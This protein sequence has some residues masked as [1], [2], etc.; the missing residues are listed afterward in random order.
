MKVEYVIHKDARGGYWAEVPALPG[1][2]TQGETLEELRENV[3]DCFEAILE[4]YAI[5]P[6][7]ADPA[8]IRRPSGVRSDFLSLR[9]VSPARRRTATRRPREVAMA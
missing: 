8:T 9:F 1:C 4:S 3:K 6:P 5:L 2:V 7:G